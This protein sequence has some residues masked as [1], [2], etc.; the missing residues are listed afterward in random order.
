M[1]GAYNALPDARVEGITRET[2]ERKER[3]GEEGMGE[4]RKI[5]GDI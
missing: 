5:E 3:K 2:R 1:L 4:K